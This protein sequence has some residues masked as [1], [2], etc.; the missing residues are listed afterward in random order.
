MIRDE[1]KST[2]SG[3]DIT[4]KLEVGSYT[5]TDKGQLVVSLLLTSLNAAAADFEFW[6]TITRSATEHPGE[7]FPDTKVEDTDTSYLKSCVFFPYVEN[8]DVIKVY[9]KSTNT[10]DTAV[11]G[12]VVFDDASVMDARKISDST[13]A[14][15]NLQ[16][17]FDGTGYDLGGI[18]VSELNQVIDDLIDGGRLDLLIDNIK[19]G[20]PT[21]QNA[22]IKYT[23]ES[24]T[25]YSLQ[26]NDAGEVWNGSTFETY[27]S[28]NW[29]TY[30]IACTE[31]LPK[32]YQVDF[33]STDVRKVMFFEQA[34]GSPA[35]SDK[36]VGAVATNQRA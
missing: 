31:V 5:A 35:S 1:T 20:I 13:T 34:G 21:P 18:D 25:I 22:F 8:G 11:S 32:M 10:N 9:A 29:S 12:E 19:D 3:Q 15:D 33:A 16:A 23:K 17:A 6:C 4:T 24:A 26:L 27:N 2:F 14:A 7:Y 30:D 36:C 28:S